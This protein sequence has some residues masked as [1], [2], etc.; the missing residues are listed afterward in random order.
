MKWTEGALGPLLAS[1]SF[2]GFVRV[3]QLRARSRELAKVYE[4]RGETSQNCV[5]WAPSRVPLLGAVSSDG[6]I[7]LLYARESQW[8]YVC[9]ASRGGTALTALCWAPAPVQQV[10][11]FNSNKHYF[12][13]VGCDRRLGFYAF[14]L[15]TEE[16][17][18]LFA[19]EDCHA[20]WVRDVSWSAAS[21]FDRQVLATASED[22]SFKVWT[23]DLT[24]RAHSCETIAGS[25]PVWR[26]SW[27]ALGN[28]LAVGL[29]SP[30]GGNVVQVYSESEERCWELFSQLA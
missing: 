13:V 12:A 17:E 14:D 7:T 30:E 20:R 18:S 26:V 29:T 8:A 19:I 22:N 16:L 24:T 1:A 3:W 10:L 21:L 11:A 4:K 2:D 23:V 15:D 25:A 27:N 5:D 6:V 28:L 9:D